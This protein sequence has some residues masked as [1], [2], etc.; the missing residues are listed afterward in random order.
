[1][2]KHGITELEWLAK[3]Y[4]GTRSA[5]T[6]LTTAA[7]RRSTTSTRR[8]TLESWRRT[9]GTRGTTSLTATASR[10]S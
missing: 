8:A 1:L 5:A 9:A 7:K 2:I 10:N 4:V 3:V 6:S